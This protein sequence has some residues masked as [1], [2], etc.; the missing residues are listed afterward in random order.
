MGALFGERAVGQDGT[1]L[2]LKV[3]VSYVCHSYPIILALYILPCI[4]SY[5]YR[6][7]SS[8]IYAMRL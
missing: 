6:P 5:L 2:L 3:I 7:I 1:H 4:S 8:N